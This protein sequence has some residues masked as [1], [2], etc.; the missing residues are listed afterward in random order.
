MSLFNYIF[1]LILQFACTDEKEYAKLKHEI[2]NDWASV[3]T[4]P[5][6][7]G[8][9]PGIKTTIKT[10]TEGPYVRLGLGVLYIFSVRW[11]QDFMNPKKEEEEGKENRFFS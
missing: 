6:H 11:I 3:I 2:E 4:D 7:D 10:Y 8:Y 1:A 9:K 5:A